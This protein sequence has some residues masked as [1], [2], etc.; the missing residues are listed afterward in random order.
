MGGRIDSAEIEAMSI[1]GLS[2]LSVVVIVGGCALVVAVV[3]L[4]I[5]AVLDNSRRNARRD[6]DQ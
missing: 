2:I 4:V 3:V 6:R 1:G 5:W